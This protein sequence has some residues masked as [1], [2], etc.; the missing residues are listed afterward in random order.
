MGLEFECSLFFF[1]RDLRVLSIESH[2]VLY[3]C[4]S[5]EEL[6]TPN[7][8]SQCLRSGGGQSL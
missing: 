2:V 4:A 1:G 5:K 8:L 7:Q 3:S 6:E